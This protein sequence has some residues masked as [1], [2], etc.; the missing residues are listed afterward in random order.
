MAIDRGMNAAMTRLRLAGILAALSPAALVA[1]LVLWTV[2]PLGLASLSF[3]R[4][5]L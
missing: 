1:A 4:R 2:L 3:S 5:E